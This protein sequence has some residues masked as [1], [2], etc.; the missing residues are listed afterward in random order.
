[1]SNGTLPHVKR[2]VLVTGGIGGP[3]LDETLPFL[4]YEGRARTRG[5]QE[6]K[7]EDIPP[8]G[9]PQTLAEYHP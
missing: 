4:E 1:M 5:N 7:H 8:P 3:H 9:C 6:M 2:D